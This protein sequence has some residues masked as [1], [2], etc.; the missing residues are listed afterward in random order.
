MIY[1]HLTVAQQVPVETMVVFF[2]NRLYHPSR[3]I[4]IIGVLNLALVC[5]ITC[6]MLFILL[7]KYCGFGDSI[8]RSSDPYIFRW[9]DLKRDDDDD[10]IPYFSPYL[11]TYSFMCVLDSAPVVML[12]V[13][14]RRIISQS[15]D[16][17]Y[18]WFPEWQKR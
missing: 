8:N 11:F 1:S 5:A 9:E 3:R 13:T 18:C 17:V 7:A 6:A 14:W 10:H 2:F 4:N 16:S 15:E 12:L